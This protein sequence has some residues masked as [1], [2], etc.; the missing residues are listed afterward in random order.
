MEEEEEGKVL[1]LLKLC[2][3]DE[4]EMAPLVFISSELEKGRTDGGRPSPPWLGPF[5]SGEKKEGNCTEVSLPPPPLSL[6]AERRGSFSSVFLC[7]PFCAAPIFLT[8]SSFPLSPPSFSR[9]VSSFPSSFCCGCRVWKGGEE[10]REGDGWM[11]V[12]G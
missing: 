9:S 7:V 10:M 1:S 3:F 11:G 4:V 8:S 2:I 12:E 5:R 6:C